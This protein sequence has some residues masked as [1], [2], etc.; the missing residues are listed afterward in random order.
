MPSYIVALYSI[1]TT[2]NTGSGGVTNASALVYNPAVP[3]E[4][5]SSFPPVTA[6]TGTAQAFD[7]LA[8]RTAGLID[9]DQIPI[10]GGYLRAAAGWETNSLTLANVDNWELTNTYLP[11]RCYKFKA[12]AMISAGNDTGGFTF[13]MAGSDITYMQ[14]TINAY[15]Q[16]AGTSVCVTKNGVGQTFTH[17][18]NFTDFYLVAEGIFCAGPAVSFTPQFAVLNDGGNGMVVSEGSMLEVILAP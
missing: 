9:F 17:T 14:Y 13:S 5:T 11:A 16:T 7:I 1:G 4:W 3:D 18:G 15:E 12:C 8:N 10:L 6:P 2:F